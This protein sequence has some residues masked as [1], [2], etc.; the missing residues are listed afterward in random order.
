VVQIAGVGICH[1]ITRRSGARGQRDC[2]VGRC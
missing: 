2:G 1:T